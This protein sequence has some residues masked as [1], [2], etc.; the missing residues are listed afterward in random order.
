MS[1][2]E[3]LVAKHGTLQEFEA[4]VWAAANGLMITDAEAMAGVRNYQ[5]ELAQARLA[6]M[7]DK[8][9]SETVS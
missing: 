9:L 4:A 1:R 3:A 2:Y 6:D 7:K 8:Q 5:D